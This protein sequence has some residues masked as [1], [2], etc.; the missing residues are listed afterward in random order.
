MVEN[1]EMRGR[2]KRLTGLRALIR[3]HSSLE[4]SALKDV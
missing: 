2:I 1:M 3:S 4:T